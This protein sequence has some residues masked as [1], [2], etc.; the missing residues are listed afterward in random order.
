[1]CRYMVAESND[2]LYVAFMGTK[3]MRDMAANA[4]I[5]L[6]ALWPTEGAEEQ[7]RADLPFPLPRNPPKMC[8]YYQAAYIITNKVSV[9]YAYCRPLQ[10]RIQGFCNEP[11]LSALGHCTSEQSHLGFG[12]SCAVCLQQP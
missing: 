5:S 8:P 6:S 11:V 1:M 12:L 10:K 3:Q 2:A 9:I 4:N 7:V